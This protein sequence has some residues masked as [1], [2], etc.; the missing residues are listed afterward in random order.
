M[1]NTENIESKKTTEWIILGNPKKYDV[2]SAFR[3]LS[4]IDWKQS[5]NVSEGDIVY[6]Y[7][8]DSVQAIRLKCRVNKVDIQVPDIDDKEF[9][10][11]G[12]YDGTHGRYMELEMIEEFSESFFSRRTLENYGFSSPQSPIRV[13]AKVK[14]YLDLIQKLLHAEEME[15]DKHDGAY[16]LVRETIRAYSE[17][18]DLSICDY[19]DLNLVYLMTIGT[20]KQKVNAKKKTVEESHL[21]EESKTKL[22]DLLD[23][24]WYR[25]ERKEYINSI[26]EGSF[27]M[28]GTGFYT[29]ERT[30]DEKSPKNFIQACIDILD[31]EDDEEIYSRMAKVLVPSYRGMRAASA[32]M[33][34]H[35]LK[36]FTFPIFN[37]NMGNDNIYVYL[38]IQLDKKTEVHT[39]IENCRKVKAFR[40]ENFK[41]KNYRI[42]DM[43]AWGLGDAKPLTDIDYIGVLDYLDNNSD[44][45]YSNP[46][47]AGIEAAE[48]ERLLDVKQKGQAAVA[49]MKKMVAICKERFGLD[50]CEPMSWLD[51]SNTKTR[52][53]LWAQMKYAQYGS[54]SISVSIFVE[55]SDVINKSR[56]RFSL[57]IKNDN[58][59]KNQ[60]EKYHSYLELPVEVESSLVYVSGSNEFG[61]MK[62]LDESA[63]EI[64]QKITDGT[65]KKVQLCR[66][67][68]WEDEL[69]NDDYENVMIEA[70]EA[71][72]PYYKHVLGIENVTYWPSTEEYNPNIS[73][74]E[75]LHILSNEQITSKEVLEMLKYILLEGGESTCANLATKYGSTAPSYNMRGSNFGKKIV[76]SI[77]H[78]TPCPDDGENRYF[79]IPFVGRAVIEDGKK[80]YSW[81]LRDELKEALEEMDLTKIDQNGSEA[82]NYGFDKNLILY[83][84]PGTGKTY[85][86]A[87]YAVAICD[88]KPLKELT[89][90]NAV[91]ERYNE[92]MKEQRIV[93][94]TFHQSYGY[95]EFIEGIKPLVTEEEADGSG[96]VSY[97]VMP[98]V[99]KE[100]CETAKRSKVKA[101][102]FD[103][104]DDATVWKAT[105]RSV[106]SE[107]CFNNNRVR[108]D[109]GI[110]SEGA[111]AFVNN[112]R[113]GDIIIT[114]GG[115]RSYI[116][117][118]AIITE[119]EAYSLESKE[120]AT[121]RD[122]MW[123]AKDIDEDITSINMNRMLSR[124]TV[125]RV[126][127]MQVGDIV[128][129][130]KDLNDKLTNTEIQQN[131]KPYVFV[132]DEINRGNISKIFGELITLIECTKREGLP[133][134]ASAVLPYSGDRFSVPKNVYILGT[135]NT[136]DRSIALMDTALRRRF[137]FVEMMPETDILRSIGA[138]K[139]GDLNV[140]DMLDVINERIGFLYDREHTIG[141]AFFTGLKEDA[142]IEK[143]K[144]I[145]EKSVIPLLQEY[146]YED[147]QKIQ[148]VLGD[149]GKENPDLKF[150]KDEKVIAKNIFKGNVEEVIDL[151]EKKYSI[152]K[153]A[154]SNIQSYIEII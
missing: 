125:A 146:F 87:T 123:L 47:A 147:Y 54:N 32:S 33:V 139:V 5:T 121:T 153:G 6:I 57:E 149:N 61:A 49:E 79:P 65:Y 98:G 78:V 25:A 27:G 59:D 103:I 132:I 66:V 113:S 89:D 111:L 67:Q 124:K 104:P 135:M 90:Y 58:S 18:E 4:K 72:I 152:N 64:K 122:V 41:I 145:F 83:G 53:Y 137:S 73:K 74:Q 50:K 86:S 42:F 143:L 7:V 19:K 76:E 138:D 97:K 129:L 116:N 63:D 128:T 108:I 120:D 133:E 37:S 34:L 45:P 112:M 126:P 17:L 106:V 117:G 44:I 1:G 150:I 93:F 134:A 71:L 80:R 119:D 62:V 82:Q 46:L 55:P 85:H 142:S 24:I 10:L 12:E 22:K 96:D 16:E 35:C 68:E 107:D 136:A 127:G 11:S 20:W 36:P 75:W 130:A 109:W 48:K 13:P 28:F 77:E 2:V 118:I 21:S 81:K 84:P 43:E 102:E 99:F 105:V 15:P 151:P 51:G 141:H 26:D 52:K 110:D 29:F 131:E 3:Y 60:M 30:T 8:S 14:V 31:L 40:D 154:L 92:L 9:D 95:E 140:A 148:M 100:F 114:T 70:V 115:S 69:S 101:N 91:M 23:T 88:D 39:Y 144:S 94:T 38:G 56:Y